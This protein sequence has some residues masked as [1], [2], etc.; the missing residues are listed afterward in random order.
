MRINDEIKK[1]LSEILRSGDL[2]D[3]R[4]GRITTVMRVDT[5]SDLKYCTVAI[6]V[7]GNDDDKAAVM[8]GIKS[9]AGYIRKLIAER[10]DLRQTPAFTFIPDDSVEYGIKM[11][12]LINELGIKGEE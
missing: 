11:T 3:P 9:A 2:K 1:E 6:S 8:Q 4:I 7:L 5:T 12:A 10:I